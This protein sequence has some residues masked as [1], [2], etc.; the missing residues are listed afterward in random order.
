MNLKCEKVAELLGKYLDKELPE[1]ETLE[2]HNHLL[3]CQSCSREFR[4]LKRDRDVVKQVLAHNP[5]DSKL[6][7]GIYERLPW[8]GAAVLPQKRPSILVRYAPVLAACAAVV[9]IAV[10]LNSLPQPP[11][12]STAYTV[13]K[14]QEGSSLSVVRGSKGELVEVAGNHELL[15]GESVRNLSSAPASF[16]TLADSTVTMRP[17]TAV[18]LTG[19]GGTV[20]IT[21]AFG[22]IYA[23]VPLEPLKI[24]TAE[25]VVIVKGTKFSVKRQD[26][27]TTVAV[28]EGEVVCLGQGEQ[29]NV[30]E[31]FQTVATNEGLSELAPVDIALLTDWV[32][33]AEQSTIGRIPPTQPVIAPTQPEPAPTAPTIPDQPVDQPHPV[34]EKK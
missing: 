19:S 11:A 7:D 1:S 23:E 6:A 28:V 32:G 15:N 33:G 20:R 21:L 31:G 26:A 25:A 16:V 8:R 12:K 29:M 30:A 13:A 14:V 17:D 5:F 34:Q 2:I 10:I 27:V 24:V 18:Q 3:T 4:F 22:E 9:L